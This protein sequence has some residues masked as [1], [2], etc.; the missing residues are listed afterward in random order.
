LRIKKRE[1]EKEFFLI[2][3]SHSLPFFSFSQKR[4]QGKDEKTMEV[5]PRA[6][7]RNDNENTL[8]SFVEK[9]IFHRKKN[10]SGSKKYVLGG[11]KRNDEGIFQRKMYLRNCGKNKAQ[12]MYVHNKRVLRMLRD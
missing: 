4:L 11:K 12:E 7:R 2:Y 9:I 1:L 5:F 10:A 8:F 6:C 3:S